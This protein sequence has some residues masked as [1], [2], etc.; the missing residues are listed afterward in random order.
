MTSDTEN[1]LGQTWESWP[2]GQ[3][4]RGDILDVLWGYDG[5]HGPVSF[6]E[7]YLLLE[8]V[9]VDESDEEIWDSVVLAETDNGEKVPAAFRQHTILSFDFVSSKRPMCW[10]KI[11]LVARADT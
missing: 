2:F 3:L 8:C 7:R 5:V 1:V 11:T 6:K 4:C 10:Q 9:A